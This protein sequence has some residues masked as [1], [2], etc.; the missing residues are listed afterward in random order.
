M[1]DATV[2]AT[3]GAGVNMGS[4]RMSILVDLEHPPNE[5]YFQATGTKKGQWYHS[6]GKI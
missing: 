5:K 2:R 1:D 4:I 6:G 3:L